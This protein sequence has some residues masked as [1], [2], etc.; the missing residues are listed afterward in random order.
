[1]TNSLPRI[2][3]SK[4]LAR[5]ALSLTSFLEWEVEEFRETKVSKYH[6]YHGCSKV[7][8]IGGRKCSSQMDMSMTW[9]CVRSNQPVDYLG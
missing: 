1:M 3:N 4:C 2:S 9:R 6:G 5:Q 7:V 8:L